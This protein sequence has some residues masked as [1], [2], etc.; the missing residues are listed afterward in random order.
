MYKLIFVLF[1]FSSL[2]VSAFEFKMRAREHYETHKV[3]ASK[4]IE[5]KGFT[6]TINLWWEKPYDISVGFFFSPLLAKFYNDSPNFGYGK[7]FRFLATGVE[8]KYFPKI[9]NFY[10]RSSLGYSKIKD[11]NSI[12]DEDGLSLYFG[13]G[14]EFSLKNFGL[15]LEVAQRKSYYSNSVEV[16]T[17]SPS[18][19]FHFY[20]YF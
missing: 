15:A 14:Y 16:D 4:N 17:F 19:G 9:Y 12:L 8:L 2:S 10:L 5:Y 7:E 6:N 18:I 3:L 1:V 13:L 20:K 11:S